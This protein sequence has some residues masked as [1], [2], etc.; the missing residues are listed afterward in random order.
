MVDDVDRITAMDERHL[1]DA[2]RARAQRPAVSGLANC[3]DLECNAPITPQRQE[4]GARL[5]IDCAK[6]DEARAAH[7]R[8]WRR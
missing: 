1:D 4:M 2:L 5:C 7:H 3:E 8:Q 6:A